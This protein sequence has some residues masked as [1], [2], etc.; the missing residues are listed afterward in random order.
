MTTA[1]LECLKCDIPSL[2]W[3][4]NT[5]TKSL[6]W[7]NSASIQVSTC[8]SIHGR[9]LVATRDIAVGECLF[10]LPPTV[11][12]PWKDVL[13]I[14]ASSQT[15]S[16][17]KSLQD[18][19]ETILLKHMKRAV[20]KH[21]ATAA[22]FLFLTTGKEEDGEKNPY[23][24]AIHSNCS[25]DEAM[26]ICLGTSLPWWNKNDEKTQPSDDMLRQIIRHNAFGPEFHNYPQMEQTL[27]SSDGSC[28]HRILGLYPLADMINH[29]CHPNA[30][31]IFSGESMM[32][33]A[34]A[35]IKKG[36]EIMYSYIPPIQ[37]Y[38]V[39]QEELLSKFHFQCHCIRCTR[40]NI[41]TIHHEE[42]EATLRD[43][44][45]QSSSPNNKNVLQS[46]VQ[47]LEQYLTSTAISNEIRHDLRTGYL[48]VYLNYLNASY[49]N[50]NNDDNQEFLSK[51]ILPLHLA[52][53]VCH[54]ASTEHLSILHFA[55]D[56]ASTQQKKFWVEQ[57]K[58]M[59]MIRYGV[60]TLEDIRQ[61]MQHTKSIL[62]SRT[63]FVQRQWA[64]L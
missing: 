7:I 24:E 20:Q 3:D 40:E 22:S 9:G 18:I 4:P 5:A 21:N 1:T 8:S 43:F 60:V 62:R 49:T 2:L 12:A 16:K 15:T 33:H 13:R 56:I 31:R 52:L 23:L 47:F 6:P 41:S 32:V 10:I 59:H 53:S 34:C 64:F 45:H 30:V 54:A 36:E 50:N 48:N 11:A 38:T 55:Y 46:K 61:T 57:L 51:L 19:A 17:S 35:N 25:S 27:S 58:R 39:R 29:S 63:G 42:L 14:Y 26:G 44:N 37:S 28:Y